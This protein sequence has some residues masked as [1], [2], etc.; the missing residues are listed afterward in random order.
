MLTFINGKSAVV[1]AKDNV[2]FKGAKDIVEKFFRD[3]KATKDGI[4]TTK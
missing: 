2:N 3:I 4:E 1:N